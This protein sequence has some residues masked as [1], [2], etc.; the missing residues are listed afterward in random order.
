MN[1]KRY[2][3]D[4]NAFIKLLSGNESIRAIIEDAKPGSWLGYISY[5]MQGKAF[6]LKRF[7]A[8][9]SGINFRTVNLNHTLSNRPEFPEYLETY[10]D[11][12]TNK[13]LTWNGRIWVDAMGNPASDN[14]ADEKR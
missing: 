4:T 7:W 8:E 11:K 14:T 13:T 6:G 5:T 3:F 12:K 9:G 10:F 2:L 1:G